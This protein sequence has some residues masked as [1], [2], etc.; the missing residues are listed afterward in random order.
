MKTVLSLRCFLSSQFSYLFFFLL[1]P[2]LLISFEPR[3]TYLTWL[4]E[5]TFN[6]ITVTVHTD[7]LTG[8]LEL[9]YSE[10]NPTVPPLYTVDHHLI[11]KP[12]HFINKR[13]LYHFNLTNLSPDQAY[14]FVIGNQKIGFSKPKKFKTPPEKSPHFRFVEGG[15]LEDPTKAEALLKIAAAY[16]PSALLLGGDYPSRIFSKKNYLVW[17]NWLDMIEKTLVTK[18]GVLIPLILA[19][20]NHEVTL[21]KSVTKT[22]K[23]TRLR[24]KVP[25]YFTY[26]PQEKEKK[27]SFFLKKFG[28]NI[29]FFILDS[30][31]FHSPLE[32]QRAWLKENLF[33][34]Q[35]L[36]YKLALYHVPTYPSVRF[37]KNNWVYRG[38]LFLAGITGERKKA[39]T[40][41]SKESWL[42]KKAWLPLFDQYQ[43]TTAFEHH[44]GTLKRTK[45]LKKN[46]I[47]SLGTVYLG[48]GAMAPTNQ[49]FPLQAF[50]HRYFA[51]IR[52]YVQFFWLVDVFEDKIVYQAISEKGKI[53]DEFTQP[54]LRSPK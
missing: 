10:I 41:I 20:G 29:V 49:I 37:K 31:H 17:D 5:E 2:F 38:L 15:D 12:S 40:L 1:F 8:P 51:K 18:E 42:Q 11:Q 34:Y 39:S 19:I 54:C 21:E 32:E 53:L 48:D 24:P 43:L 6:H 22:S 3:H 33:K 36:D 26:F 52:G 28:Q 45:P 27:Q 30:G 14:I 13:F 4:S 25:F 50:L 9:L 44:D 46:K 7:E 35:A 23:K 47:N 16:S